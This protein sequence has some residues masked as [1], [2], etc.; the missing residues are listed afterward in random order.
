M[1]VKKIPTRLD[2][3][4]GDLARIRA[5]LG[6]IP[7]LVI[8]DEAD[9]ASLNTLRPTLNANERS[10]RT[11][12]NKAIVGLLAQLPRAQYVGYTATPFA[13]VFVDPD[14]AEDLFPKDFI[15]GLP[16]PKNY[17]GPSEFHDLGAQAVTGFDSN[18]ETHVRDIWG[19]DDGPDN[20]LKALDSFV[21]SGAIKLYRK[22]T[23]SRH[24]FKH[25]TMLVHESPR[26]YEHRLIAEAVE[27]TLVE[28]DYYGSAGIDRLKEL[29]Q[30]DF[31]PVSDARAPDLP[32]PT[33]FDQLKP[34]LDECLTRIDS[35]GKAVLVVNSEGEPETPDFDRGQVWKIIVGGTKLSRGYTIEGLTVSYYRRRAGAADTLMQMGRWFG[36]RDGYRDLVRLFI[37]RSEPPGGRGHSDLYS[38]FEAVCRDEIE[39]R[40]ELRRYSTNDA[41][42]EVITPAQVPPLVAS[43]LLPPTARNKMFNAKIASENFGG[44]RVE[45]TLAPYAIADIRYN[46]EIFKTLLGKVSLERTRVGVE[47]S[48]GR[49]FNAILGNTNNTSVISFL[50]KYRWQTRKQPMDRIVDFLK[51]KHGETGIEEWLILAPQMARPTT[52]WRFLDLDWSVFHRARVDTEGRYHVYSEPWH[53]RVARYLC[54]L[55]E[56]EAIN[57]TTAGLRKGK[58]GVMLVYPVRDNCHDPKTFGRGK[59]DQYV[60]I[61]FALLFPTNEISAPIR[62]TVEDPDQPDEITVPAD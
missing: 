23:D 52:T 7:A 46:I 17:M 2:Q 40:R 61:G 34:Y 28:A 1:V 59:G 43:H 44:R 62:F 49:D 16:K 14:D 26:T 51:G 5:R 30:S 9:Q 29:Y 13:N 35:G 20:L 19:E 32:F 41:S 47:G 48:D 12:T 42:E 50:E 56:G 45:R 10:S 3:V 24:A 53:S 18:K 8:D 22:E 27:K 21:L 37:G 36:F 4:T 55:D 58:Q 15:I 6:D 38:A 33:D 25:H 60:N 57:E 31:K 54:S 39:L 11:K